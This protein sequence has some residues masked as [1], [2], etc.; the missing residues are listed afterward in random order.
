MK[1]IVWIGEQI[2][3]LLIWVALLIALPFGLL[4]TVPRIPRYR[5]YKKMD[6]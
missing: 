2:V 4:R 3:G 5:R 1:V 6:A